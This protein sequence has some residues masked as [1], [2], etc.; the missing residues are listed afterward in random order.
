MVL[1]FVLV[2]LEVLI[3]F[4]TQQNLLVTILV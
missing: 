4:S 1:P 3:I 2:R